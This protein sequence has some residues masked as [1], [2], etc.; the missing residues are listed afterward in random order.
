M[1]RRTTIR[2]V[3]K[4]AEVSISTVSNYLNGRFA[5]MSG[6][7]RERVAHAIEELGYYPSLGAQ[8][9][10]RKRQT[11]TICIVIPHNVDYTFHH[12]YFAEVMRGISGV[13]DDNG[14]RA[15]ILTTKDKGRAEVTY[16][17]SLTRGIVDGIIFFDVEESDPFI[18][19]FG[20]SSLPIMFVGR[21]D[22]EVTRFVDNDVEDGADKA[23]EHLIS[24]GHTRLILLAGPPSLMFTKQLI[25]GVQQ[26][27][28]RAGLAWGTDQVI[29]GEFSESSGIE[30]AVKV[31]AKSTP[32]TAVFAASGKQALGF[33]EYARKHEFAIPDSVS[34]I[35][36]GHHPVVG[37]LGRRL[38]Y[39]DQP[40]VDVGSRVALRLLEQIEGSEEPDG[41]G[42]VAEVLPLTLVVG[43][44][45]GPPPGVG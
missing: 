41:T 12:T 32:A 15:M 8:A 44:S 45:T 6:P 21:A 43:E 2:E 29:Y 24:L 10:P 13:L 42:M 16:L 27:F 22:K 23:A 39:L 3:A 11:H 36:F 4:L 33:M 28:E 35:S 37:A 38:T 17:R 18:E 14:Y 26:A 1:D 7:T 20:A 19:A 25:A 30:G 31:F 9:L 34:L 5:N 40:E